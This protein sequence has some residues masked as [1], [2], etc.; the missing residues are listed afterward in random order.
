MSLA[1]LPRSDSKWWS[2]AVKHSNE[3]K[4]QSCNHF[5]ERNKKEVTCRKCNMGFIAD[6]SLRIEKGKLIV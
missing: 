5:F 4:E 3:V 1:G 2:E 6:G